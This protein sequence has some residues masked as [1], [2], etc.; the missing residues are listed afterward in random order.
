MICKFVK[1]IKQQ[2]V[3]DMGYLYPLK[4]NPFNVMRSTFIFGE[5]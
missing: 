2:V 3:I 4:C 1:S 5:R